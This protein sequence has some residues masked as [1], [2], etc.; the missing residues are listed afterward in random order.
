MTR[1]VLPI[2]PVVS[3]DGNRITDHNRQPVQNSST[4]IETRKRMANGQMRTFVV[5]LKSQFKLSWKTV[6]RQNEKTVDGFWGAESIE[7]FYNSTT[8]EFV[9]TLT[10]GDHTTENFTVL[11]A[12][13]SSTLSSRSNW[14]DLYDI[15]L[16]LDEV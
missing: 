2:G 15:D 12:S 9:I 10:N 11:F 5:A 4:R 1:I 3:F 14:T 13:F 6:P 16:T 7:D 8:N